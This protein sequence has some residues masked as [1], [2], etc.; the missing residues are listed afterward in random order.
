MIM[1]Y[2]IINYNISNSYKHFGKCSRTI[3]SQTSRSDIKMI[4]YK[5]ILSNYKP[6][7]LKYKK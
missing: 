3:V 2:L 4:E 7:T 6:Y 1:I 5:I